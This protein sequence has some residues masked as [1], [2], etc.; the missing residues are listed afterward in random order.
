MIKV[1]PFKLSLL[2]LFQLKKKTIS[3]GLLCD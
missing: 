3:F 2:R 1:D